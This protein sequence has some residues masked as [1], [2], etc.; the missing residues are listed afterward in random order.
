MSRSQV[1]IRRE[2]RPVTRRRTPVFPRWMVV[3][4]GAG[5]LALG[6]HLPLAAET[7]PQPESLPPTVVLEL[8]RIDIANG[9]MDLARERLGLLLQRHPGHAEALKALAE[10][11]VAQQSPTHLR[12]GHDNHELTREVRLADARRLLARGEDEVQRGDPERA[13]VL[14]ERAEAALG[15]GDVDPV[16][17]ELRQRIAARGGEVRRQIAEGRS[18]DRTPT[19][20]AAEAATARYVAQ[21]G[22]RLTERIRRIEALERREF[23]QLALAE[24]RALLRDHP[25]EPRVRALF[26]RL[27]DSSHAQRELDLEE[28]HQELHQ[29]V[30]EQLARSLIPYGFGT[31]PLFPEDWRD[32][33]PPNDSILDQPQQLAAADQVLRERLLARTTVNVQEQD[34]VQVLMALGA[35]FGLNLVIDPEV[36]NA[37]RLVT[38][39]ARDITVEHALSWICRLIETNWSQ[40][41]GGIY[42]GVEVDEVPV[43]ALYDISEVIF[44]PRD[45]VPRWRLGIVAND[46]GAATPGTLLAPTGVD[47]E[48]PAIAPEDLVDEI[49]QAISPPTWTRE[50][51]SIAIRRNSLLVTAPARVHLLI[52]EFIRAYM[53]RSRLLVA[54]DAR[55]VTIADHYLEEIGVQWSTSGSLLTLPGA[56]TAGFR[57][58]TSQFAHDGE[59]INNLPPSAIAA[60]PAT[61]GSGLSLSGVL[62]DAVQL[63]AVL[64]AV[65][66]NRKINVVEGSEIVT[67]NGVRAYSFFGRFI[68]YLGGYDVGAGAGDALGATLTPSVSILRL[69]ALLEVKPF[70]SSDRKYVK[71]EFGS[72]LAVLEGFG[73]ESL[74]VIRS[75]PVGFDP[76]ANNG[77]GEPIVQNAV[78]S[79]GIELPLVQY[80]ELRTYI[81]IPDGGTM[82]VGGWGR[83]VEQSMSTKIPF[84]GHIP[85]LGRLFG[86]RGR[87]SDRHKIS[88]LVGVNIIDYAEL[89]EQ[90]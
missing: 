14:F 61:A 67:F 73:S 23:L 83:Y 39:N 44:Q 36:A 43:T 17:I 79:F 55:W 76:D 7:A 63:S 75:Y 52:R 74:Q 2:P 15:Q 51:C 82:L 69:G 28:R 64:T 57:R 80:T 38:L 25:D 10:L 5:L 32:R 48:P 49:T 81:Q 16:F 13:V 54:I 56:G 1:P 3:A 68:S 60:N 19:R 27:L 70:V 18:S 90:Q 84:L 62:L 86:Q 71:M 88:L 47:D 20:Q 45:Q 50:D 34:A 77:Q 24:C 29:E 4:M 40:G 65:E 35:Q 72:T 89:E 46:V 42:I 11:G 66:R 87:Y 9:R 41:N 12:G 22:L 6:H 31:G 59:L 53:Q 8:A 37:G 85:F 30:Q 58:A 26:R 78:Q 21:E 33:H